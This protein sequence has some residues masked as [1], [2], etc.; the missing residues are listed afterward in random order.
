MKASEIRIG[1]VYRTRINGKDT[2]VR[3]DRKHP[4]GGWTGT[5]LASNRPVRIKSAQ[6]LDPRSEEPEREDAAKAA[7]AVAEGNLVDGVS[8]PLPA[9]RKKLTAKQRRALRSEA[10]ADQANARVRDERDASPDGMTASERAMAE[11]EQGRGGDQ[12]KKLSCLDAA[13]EVLRH[14]GEP[15][16]CGEMMKRILSQELWTT[17]GRTPAAT[18]YSGILREIR[19]KGDEARFVQAERG[20]FTIKR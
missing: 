19:R 17:A 7:Q 13:E 8:V 9:A 4:D 14:A 3:I 18:L 11:S 6:K 5:N 16:T 2:E 15:L 1:E 12:S 20:K 10:K